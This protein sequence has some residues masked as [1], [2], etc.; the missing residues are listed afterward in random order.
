MKRL[1]LM[2]L[3]NFWRVPTAY[4]KLCHYA[5]N[6]DRYSEEEKYRHIQYIMKT[7]VKSG[8]V[9]LK[10]YGKENMPENDG[11]M[12]YANHQ[13]LFDIV[14]LAASCEKPWAVVLKKELNKLPVLKQM[15]D[16]TKSFP[17]DREDVRQS[18]KVIQA[19]T[20]EV[21]G[22]RNYLIF[23]EGTRS[24]KG[25]K[26][27]DFHGGSFKCAL[28]AKCT[29]LPIAFIDSFKVLDQKGTGKVTV[30]LHYLEPITYEEYKDLKTIELA[31][32]VRSRI[33]KVVSENAY[34]DIWA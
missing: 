24:K 8:N 17:M 23:P 6:T 4:W 22:G 11:F 14:A 26:L 27:L 3:K 31:Q 13:G 28:K 2:I 29:I 32:L 18:M 25:N 20:K 19:V 12:M 33:E 34:C 1:L 16:C 7:A 30:Q 21:E 5:K 9:D 15:V 10:V